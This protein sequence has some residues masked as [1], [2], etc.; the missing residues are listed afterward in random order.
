MYLLFGQFYYFYLSAF[1]QSIGIAIFIYSISYIKNR[2]LWKYTINILL[3]FFFHKSAVILYPIYFIFNTK[4]KIKM[5]LNI[6]LYLILNLLIL[7][8]QI[9]QKIIFIFF[10]II[11]ILKLGNLSESYLIKE[12]NIE[13]KNIVFMLFLMILYKYLTY[14]KEDYFINKI[15]FCYIIIEILS[16]IIGIFY[17]VEIYFTVFYSIFIVEIFFKCNKNIIFKVL[18]VSLILFIGLNYNIKAI[19][20]KYTE[21]GSL[22]PLHF[23]FERIYKD[24]NYQDTAEYNHLLDRYEDNKNLNELN[25]RTIRNYIKK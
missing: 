21:V 19:L 24:I 12:S 15:L 1:R 8:P 16:K 13:I 10:K 22:I 4:V 23:T 2:Q 18:R 20:I 6:F 14:K 17:R 11:N 9:R 5:K 3:A 7:I 25:E